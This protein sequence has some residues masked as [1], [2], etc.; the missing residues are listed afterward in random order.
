M[1][2]LV[3]FRLLPVFLVAGFL[4][5][6]ILLL[7]HHAWSHPARSGETSGAGTKLPTSRGLLVVGS[8]YSNRT[9]P[10]PL[11]DA[12]T[13]T[14]VA[15]SSQRFHIGGE[16][17]WIS[18]LLN[19]SFLCQ[20]NED[21]S[22]PPS[23]LVLVHSH[24]LH[25]PQRDAIRDTWGRIAKDYD[26]SDQV[27]LIFLLGI[28]GNV[29]DLTSIHK[30]SMMYRDVILA[31]FIDTYRN[32]TV[33]S[34]TGLFWATTFC[35]DSPFFLKTDDDVY[36]NVSGLLDRLPTISRET[37]IIGALNPHATVM[38]FG[39]WRV[40]ASQYPDDFYPPYCAGCAYLMRAQAATTIMSKFHR[41]PILP[42]EDVYIT[43]MVA[44]EASLQCTNHE[45]F[46]HWNMGPSRTH[47]CAIVKQN[48]LAI[49]NVY[50]EMMYWI[51][52]NIT[53]RANCSGI[54]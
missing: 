28:T 8:S 4:W 45:L 14:G 23:L 33:K 42:I 43:G 18:F 13:K 17:G 9:Q 51:H 37:T 21:V 12:A 39:M 25:K 41:V 2:P 34:L 30:E 53:R 31:D 44:E 11:R 10:E 24:P 36:F 52:Q 3:S 27:R 16:I 1:P 6:T 47:V 48:L 54:S 19:P 38:R 46:P 26:R 7:Q 50:Y 40:D 49:H 5:H 20:S 35:P 15:V 32:L 29:S 22:G